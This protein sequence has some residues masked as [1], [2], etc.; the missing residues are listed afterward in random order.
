MNLNLDD[1]E[2]TQNQCFVTPVYEVQLA[3]GDAAER[4]NAELIAQ[5]LAIRATGESGRDYDGAGWQTPHDLHRRPAFHAFFEGVQ[6]VMAECSKAE[7]L[8]PE[9]RASISGAWSNIEAPGDFVRIHMHP[10]SVW[11][12]V[13]YAQVDD[14][15]G[16]IYFEDPRPG[17]KATVWPHAQKLTRGTVQFRP[18]P[19]MMLLFPSYLEHYTD[20]NRSTRERICLAFNAGLGEPGAVPKF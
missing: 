3:S 11:S 20:P 10:W 17:A 15:T 13:Y 18:R 6:R 5:V 14:K 9:Q 1:V 16:D 4:L 19:G 7:L 12:G 2:L 8:P